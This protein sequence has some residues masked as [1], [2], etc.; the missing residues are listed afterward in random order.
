MRLSPD[1]RSRVQR[2]SRIKKKFFLNKFIKKTHFK[3]ITFFKWSLIIEGS[4]KKR[5][6]I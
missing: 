3:G 4:I 1:A 2:R 5:I 6:V